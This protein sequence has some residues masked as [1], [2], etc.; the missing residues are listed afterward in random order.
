MLLLRTNV[1]V[2]VDVALGGLPFESELISRA[3]DVVYGAGVVLHICTGEDLVVLKAFANRARDHADLIGIA[4]RR[5]PQLDWAA[6]LDRLTPL[7]EV[8]EEPEILTRVRDLQGEFG[9]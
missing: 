1:G 7:V 8:K 5:G 4:R 3:V 9:A 2:E 6:I